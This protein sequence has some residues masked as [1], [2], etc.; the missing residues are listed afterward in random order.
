MSVDVRV[1]APSGACAIFKASLTASFGEFKQ[2]IHGDTGVL[3]GVEDLLFSRMAVQDDVLLADQFIDILCHYLGKTDSSNAAPFK[4]VLLCM[5]SAVELGK[6]VEEVPTVLL[7]PGQGTQVVGMGKL[8]LDHPGVRDLYAK[9]SGILGFDLLRV[10]L[11]GPA[12]MLEDTRYSQPA[13]LVTSY[14]SALKLQDE[15][16]VPRGACAACA[17]F[18]LGEFTAL[19]FAGAM[20]FEV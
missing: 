8:L 4:D 15:G 18:S 7:F 14:A 10:C 13:I 5:E 16:R 6:P 1:E 9:A 2:Q 11:D 3:L 17:G 12:E 19:V 20:S